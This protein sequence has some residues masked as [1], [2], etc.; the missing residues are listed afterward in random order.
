[1]ALVITHIFSRSLWYSY[2][3]LKSLYSCLCFISLSQELRY[4]ILDNML[5][6]TKMNRNVSKLPD[7]STS[8]VRVQWKCELIASR[9][10]S[11]FSRNACILHVLGTIAENIH[12]FSLVIFKIKLMH[13]ISQI[14]A[15]Y[16]LCPETK[17]QPHHKKCITGLE[18]DR[19]PFHFWWDSI[20]LLYDSLKLIKLWWLTQTPLRFIQTLW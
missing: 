10:F 13:R 9:P 8:R 18:L 17:G 2:Y 12:C 15:W 5:C 16:S 7:R 3:F 14:E 1:M 20:R 11:N 19:A 4:K 6:N